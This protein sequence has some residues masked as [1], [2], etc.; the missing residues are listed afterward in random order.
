MARSLRYFATPG[1]QMR[2]TSM[3]IAMRQRQPYTEVWEKRGSDMG[4]FFPI[5]MYYRAAYPA[6]PPLSLS[7]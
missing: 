4:S 6:S 3:P 2:I 1:A 7:K 5:Q